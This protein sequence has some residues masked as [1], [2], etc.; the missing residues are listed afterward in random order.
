MDDMDDTQN[1]DFN[2]SNYTK[3][4]LHKFLGFEKGEIPSD[5]Q[6]ANSVQEKTAATQ[7]PEVKNFFQ[8][9]S[10]RLLKGEGEKGESSDMW[11]T[12]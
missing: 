2:V 6:I 3:E 4:N 8:K 1:M 11:Q 12:E 7:K 10:D 9:I 5:Q